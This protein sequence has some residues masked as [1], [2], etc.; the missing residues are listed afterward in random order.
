MTRDSSP[1]HLVFA[2]TPAFAIPSLE[3]LANNS[4]FCVDLVV[5]QP[6]R[7]VGRKGVITP[8][9]VKIAA[10]GLSVPVWQPEDINAETRSSE[11]Q[12]LPC[13]FLVVVAFGQILAPSILAIPMIAPI[14]LHAS[15]L[16]RWRGASPI[17]HAILAGDPETGVT[18][19]RMVK[20]LDAG[21][22]LAQERT[23]IDPRET[24][25]SL[26]D[27]LASMGA[28]LLVET[29]QRPCEPRKQSE[30]HVTH[31]KKLSRASGVVD[32]K[33]MT[34]EEIDRCVRALHP[35]PGVTL[36]QGDGRML[37]ILAADLKPSAGAAKLACRD[38]TT[39]YLLRVQTA[40]GKPLTGQEW[41]RGKRP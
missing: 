27:R 16:P 17:Q 18:V 31:C 6:D 22:V 21:P 24:Y 2:G 19:Q 25:A 30:D 38:A 9:P 15:L 32:P 10:Q 33:T 5:T 40:G 13:D 36:M 8:P 3:A 35:W 20:E 39:L 41:E 28:R 11:L 12:A 23:P 26:H 29:L 4:A 7:P 34:A 37:K 1:L 14:N